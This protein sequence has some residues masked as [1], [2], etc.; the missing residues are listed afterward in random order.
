[1]A[2]FTPLTDADLRRVAHACGISEDLAFRGI[3]D[4]I[5][6]S[7]F[8][9]YPKGSNT[10]AKPRW[11]LTIIEELDPSEVEFVCA[12]LQNLA[13]AGVSVA[14][15]ASGLANADMQRI[16]GK[17]AL[18]FGFLDGGHI[19]QADAGHCQQVG[20]ELARAHG[21]PSGQSRNCSHGWGWLQT[22]A[23][24]LRETLSATQRQ[25]L[26]AEMAE[27]GAWQPDCQALPEAIIHA[28]LFRDNVMFDNDQLSGLIDWYSACTGAMVYD[29]AIALN[30]WCRNPADQIDPDLSEAFLDGYTRVR[31]LAPA[32]HAALALAQRRAA[33]RFWLSRLEAARRPPKEEANNTPVLCKTKDPTEFERLLC[34]LRAQA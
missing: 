16:A 2:V 17:P 34:W 15:P 24:E 33:L 4:G 6:N 8:L 25:L 26:D 7:S 5:E 28:D 27:Q 22:A 9:I 32:E 29:I 20:H 3:A 23:T 14:A 21:V 30:D 12:H 11:V 18:L 13:A 1:M 31:A 19:D 10:P